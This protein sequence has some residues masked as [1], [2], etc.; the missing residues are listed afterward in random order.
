MGKQWLR[1]KSHCAIV[2]N[3]LRGL[4]MNIKEINEILDHRIFEGSEYG[5][6]CYPNG[7]FL[8]Y[9]SDHAQVSVV[10]ST[11]NQRV[12]QAEIWP[13]EQSQLPIY[14]WIDPEFL[15]QYKAECKAR[16]T[17]FDVALDAISYVDLEVEVDF[18]EKAQAI[19]NNKPFDPR[20]LVQ[21]D[22]EDDVIL[23]LAIEAHKRD[24]TINQMVE[25]LLRLAME[26]DK[27]INA[28]DT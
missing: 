18:L 20:I 15:P 21:L 16:G 8:D 5:W 17:E 19:F 24:I 27:Y 11:E 12:Y 3:T 14:R 7:R 9:S 4:E 10:F 2:S 28:S 22:L 13:S 26:S 1:L 23:Q 25:Q 6:S